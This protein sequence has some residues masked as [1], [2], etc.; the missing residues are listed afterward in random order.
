MSSWIISQKNIF[1]LEEKPKKYDYQRFISNYNK[2]LTLKNM[3]PAVVLVSKLTGDVYDLTSV[4][5][6]TKMRANL[7]YNGCYRKSVFVDKNDNI[8]YVNGNVKKISTNGTVTAIDYTPIDYPISSVNEFAVDNSGNV[9][10]S[11][12]INFKE[13]FKFKKNDGRFETF[14]GNRA[15]AFTGLDGQIYCQFD[16]EELSRISLDNNIIKKEEI[17]VMPDS[18]WYSGGY[19]WIVLNNRIIRLPNSSNGEPYQT[20]VYDKSGIFPVTENI[21]ALKNFRLIEPGKSFYYIATNDGKILKIN[22]LDTGNPIVLTSGEYDILNM[23][24]SD[25]EIVLFSGLRLS[26]GKKVFGEIS[27]LGEISIIEENLSKEITILQKIN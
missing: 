3:S 12:E 19:I 10:F 20:I 26:D 21:E 1:F 22:P 5:A 11:Y 4:G 14:E 17:G 2:I 9:F 15:V 18:A 6:P 25:S 24:I 27:S 13:F 7:G 8:Y 16:S 23:S